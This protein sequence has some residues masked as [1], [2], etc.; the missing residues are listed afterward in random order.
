MSSSSSKLRNLGVASGNDIWMWE[1]RQKLKIPRV[2]MA[3]AAEVLEQIQDFLV[4]GFI[5]TLLM[6]ISS[7]LFPLTSFV[8]FHKVLHNSYTTAIFA[9]S[10]ICTIFAR[11]KIL[12][13]SFLIQFSIT[14]Q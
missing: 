7:P 4:F 3:N 6:L 13:T 1:M 5:L 14:C 9:T 11:T 8:P 12:T 2:V 10:K